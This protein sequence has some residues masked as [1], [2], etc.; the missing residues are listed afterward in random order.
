[1]HHEAMTSTQD[2][3]TWRADEINGKAG[4]TRA[5]TS[6]ELDA[7]DALIDA[8]KAVPVLQ[9][10]PA[11]F[12]DPR[13]KKLAHDCN[14]ELVRGRGGIILTGFD[15]ARYEFDDYRRTYWYLGC[16]L[17]EPARQSERG[18]LLGYVRQ[19]KENPY[20][21]GYISNMELAFHNDFHEVLSLACVKK[22]SVG[23]ESGLVSSLT[24]HNI[25]LKERPDLLAALYEGWY[26]GMEAFY[27][28]FRRKA[29]L[30]SNFVPFFYEADGRPWL[31]GINAMFSNK[32]AVE[33]DEAMPAILEEALA[34]LQAIAA[35][36]GIAA[37][38]ILE[39]GEMIFWHN[40]TL[41]HARHSFVNQPG[42]ER[43]LMRLWLYPFESRVKSGPAPDRAN[44]VDRIHRT[45]ATEAPMSEEHPLYNEL[46]SGS[47]NTR[48]W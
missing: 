33:R 45:I 37:R 21:R 6:G 25:L 1:M 40:W 42:H 38:F 4:L 8:T 34:A 12:D 43:V 46:V 15:P 22:A 24:I 48:S 26:D 30:N 18:D 44:A 19:E 35:R 41:L 10:R 29:D 36:P 23:G 31:H 39:P 20:G 7:L 3:A 17:G 13:L 28:I 9:L 14:G 5:L 2:A 32:A 47:G 11:S 16:L 27:K